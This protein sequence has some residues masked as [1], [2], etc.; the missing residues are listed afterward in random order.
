[1]A[2]D[3]KT[4]KRKPIGK[5]AKEL[6]KS[7]KKIPKYEVNYEE[8]LKKQLF[9]D[10][11]KTQ[12]SNNDIDFYED[13]REFHHQKR[14]GEW[15]V[16]LDEKIWYFDPELSYEITGF[17]P[18]NMT[19]GL[20][21]DPTLFN[22]AA[23]TYEKKG[24]YTEFPIGSKPYND[25]W[26]EQMRRCVEGY[27]VGK[28]RITG[29]HYFFLNFYRMQ[30]ANLNNTK[31]VTGRNESFPSFLSK[32]YEF[33]HYVEMCEYLGM[34]VCM[35]K[36][37]GLGFSEILACLG[38]RPFTTTRKF[39]SV[40]TADSDAH[41]NPTLT[42][43]WTQLNWLNT[44]T[45]GGM[46][47]LRQ[48]IDNMYRK[49]A[50]M[51]NSQGDEFGPMSEIEGIVADNPGKVRGDRTERLI[52]E[53]AGSNKNLVTSW[54]QGDALVNLG[55]V[56]VG[57]KLAGGTGGDSGP[58]L[59]GLAKMF[60]DPMSYGILPY[61]NFYTRDGRVQ[62]T[63]FFIPAHEF[64]LRPEYLDNRG[65]T[66]SVRFKKFYEDKR[67]GMRG[68]DA[69]TYAAENCFTPD[70][71]LLKQGDNIFDSELISNQLT[72]MA[73]S[74]DW[75]KPKP[76]GLM[77]DRSGEKEYAAVN[78]FPVSNSKLLV[79]EEPQ[80][81]E[82]G[83][84]YK[85]LYV[86]GIDAID[87]GKDNSAMDTDVSEFCIVIKKR[88]FGMSPSQYVAIYKDRPRDIQVAY[89]MAFKLLIWYN[90]RAVLEFTKIGFQE[91][92][93]NKKRGDLLMERPEFATS[94]RN[95]KRTT[96]RLIGIPATESVINHG[97]ELIQIQL[98]EGWQDIYFEEML[99]QLLNYSYE[100]K[101]KFDIIAAL[102][103]TEIGDEELMDIKPVKANAVSNQWQDIGWYKNEK[104][105][106]QFGVIPNKKL[107]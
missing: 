78:A 107:I 29:D 65:V 28:Y 49:R 33:F 73:T 86:A 46:K 102:I 45:N 80:R 59:A 40:Y 82:D 37:R 8:E 1:M 11:N 96:K 81:L 94:N 25:Y 101:R 39:R 64:S 75:P 43:V 106:M 21:F 13:V 18:I 15:D 60:R 87:Q 42:K 76:M 3:K 71:A 36:A 91:F 16:P 10:E 90:A 19:E 30:T 98:S 61:K 41:L 20:D 44:Q 95:K 104:G 77:W 83:S 32:Q 66:D 7:K 48:K 58:A 105:Y 51:V 89:D 67:A 74:N 2:I 17:R 72:F 97:L 50:S 27:T 68:Q 55:G 38:V 69:I 47:H 35:L 54:V 5:A 84:V 79:L 6:E 12:E 14:D 53:E 85:N 4:G 34:D 62:Y 63:G 23:R 103:C 24:S 88:A 57:I 100:D 92:L 9:A 52:F 56:K 93:K 22:E 99:Y 26:K 31:A 70:E